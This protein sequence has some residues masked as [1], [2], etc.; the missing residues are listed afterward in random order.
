[1]RLTMFKPVPVALAMSL[2][3]SALASAAPTKAPKDAEGNDIIKAA[4]VTSRLSVHPL[5]LA[6]ELGYF[7]E[8]RIK[9]HYAGALGAASLMP[10]LL[11][12]NIDI[13]TGHIPRAITATSRGG[14]L[15]AVAAN[16]HTTRER[17]HMTYVVLANSPIKSWKDVL[18]KRVTVSAWGGCN[19]YTAL[20]YIRGKGVTNPK[21]K[22]KTQVVNGG[23]EETV[24]RTGNTDVAGIHQTPDILLSHGGLRVLFSDYDIWGEEGGQAPYYMTDEFIN[25]NPDL[26]R[27]FVGV[28]SK[29]NNF[30]DANPL[31][32]RTIYAKRY[33]LK[34]ENVS[35]NY[36]EPNA[37]IQPHTVALWNDILLA[38]G[39]IK[40]PVPIDQVYT[41]EYNPHYRKK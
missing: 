33:N 21:Q 2:L 32:A 30:I 7:K 8:A 24:L 36:Y 28:V 3:F 4:S 6:E 10:A 12:G 25:A 41:N 18:G 19:E 37:I 9:I 15:K 13:T 17:P 20:E 23:T 39:D 26:V 31:K 35:I 27:R 11:S 14:K 1:M 22:I 38:Y 5:E 34:L 40:K 29:V 16:T